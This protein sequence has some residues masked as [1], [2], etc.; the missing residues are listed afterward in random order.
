M[1]IFIIL[2]YY[3]ITVG[4]LLDWFCFVFRLYKDPLSYTPIG[5]SQLYSK[6]SHLID[7]NQHHGP[8]QS[9]KC[10]I[11]YQVSIQ[12]FGKDMCQREDETP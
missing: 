10:L 6:S 9:S 3:E 2:Y 7:T 8:G 5:S 11:L 1:Y 4:R 12:T